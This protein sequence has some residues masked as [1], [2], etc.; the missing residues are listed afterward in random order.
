[1]PEEIKLIYFATP[2]NTAVTAFLFLSKIYFYQSVYRKPLS[3][4]RAV[5][6]GKP[7][8]PKTALTSWSMVWYFVLRRDCLSCVPL[9]KSVENI[10]YVALMFQLP[11][12]LPAGGYRS[13]QQSGQAAG[14]ATEVQ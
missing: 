1:M 5:V 14:E 2:E 12:G 4:P 11:L 9:R 13:V 3:Q 7:E 10:Q 6:S 8:A